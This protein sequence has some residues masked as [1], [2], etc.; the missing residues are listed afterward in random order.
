MKY[1]YVGG[2]SVIFLKKLSLN[3]DEK[4]YDMLQEIASNDNGFHNKVNG[5]SYKEFR[6]WLKKEYAVDN[7]NLEKWMVPQTSYWL[8]DD[9]KPI[10]YGRIRHYLN[11]NLEKSGGH[12]G[13][14]IRS[15]ERGKGY[16]N[17]ILTL[18]LE[19]CKT[20]NIGTVQ[21]GANVDNIPSNRIILN[22]NGVLFRC[23]D[24]KNFY[25]INLNIK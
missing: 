22:H 20:L 8:Y 3:D 7:G 14:A 4:I 25:H 21:I 13:Y 16:G 2:A 1:F 10:G 6:K 19:E 12:I 17:T 5:M 11:D 24:G 9:D 18:L 23:S 15:T